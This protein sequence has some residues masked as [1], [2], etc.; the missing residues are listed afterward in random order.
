[1]SWNVFYSNL[2]TV[3][4]D[5]SS[6]CLTQL[7]KPVAGQN[8]S[9]YNTKSNVC[10]IKHGPILNLQFNAVTLFFQKACSVGV[11]VF[12][13]DLSVKHQTVCSADRVFG[14]C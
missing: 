7:C 3:M 8:S 12:I 11:F 9:P 4:K 10:D 1:M 6:T 14:V 5:N 2:N 13:C